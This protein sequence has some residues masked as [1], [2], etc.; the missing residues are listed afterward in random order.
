VT[1]ALGPTSPREATAGSTD[2]LLELLQSVRRD[3]SLREEDPSGGWVERSVEE[4]RDGRKPGWYY[5]PSEGGGGIAFATVRG[6]RAW[7]HVH[8]LEE[9]RSR[10]L[11]T[12]LLDG[13]GEDIGAISLGFTGLP[14]E[15]ERR[16]ATSLSSR[17]GGTV[18]ERYAMDRALRADDT[19]VGGEPPEGLRRVAVRD[20]TLAALADLDWRAFRG[21]VDDLMVGGSPEEYVR[22]ITS[23]LENGQGRFL[24]NASTVLIAS[25]PDRLIGAVLTSEITSREAIFLDLMVDPEQRGRGYGR[26]LL[27]WAFRSL[28][29]L[30]YEKVRLW[31]TATNTTALRLYDE[32]GFGRVATTI[33]YRWDRPLGD[34]QAQRSR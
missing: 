18:I 16:L 27:R 4:L 29:G 25:E 30:G 17:P 8:S 19:K 6:S 23:L 26:F 20:V 28:R 2:E 1:P 24:D 15:V 21:S 9:G 10:S 7:G 22:M 5:P 32:E 3:V 11:A 12:A 13:L 34:P 31:V 14:I 33:I